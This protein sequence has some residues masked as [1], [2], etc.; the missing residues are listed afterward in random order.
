MCAG[1]CRIPLFAKLGQTS[2]VFCRFLPMVDLNRM[3]NLGTG[4]GALD[5][6]LS[7]ANAGRGG[8]SSRRKGGI[9]V[10]LAAPLRPRH[11]FRY[12]RRQSRRH[13]LSASNRVEP[14]CFL[15]TAMSLCS[16]IEVWTAGHFRG[17]EHYLTVVWAR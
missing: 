7:S 15:A 16:A 14:P 9:A 1:R 10:F 17:S 3:L 6:V 8:A 5:T 2:G 12:R 13:R 4:L 11:A